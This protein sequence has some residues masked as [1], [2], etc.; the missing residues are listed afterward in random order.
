MLSSISAYILR[1]NMD[2]KNLYIQLLRASHQWRDLKNRMEKG[3]RHQP[4]EASPDGSMAVFC[5]ACP[6]P[7]VNLPEDWNTRYQP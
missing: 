4:E 2:S 1:A 5:P 7:G 3:L 6:Q